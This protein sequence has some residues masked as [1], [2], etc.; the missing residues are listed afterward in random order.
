[1]LSKNEVKYIHSLFRKKN[2][3]E[4]RLFIAEGPKL[5]EELLRTPELITHVYATQQWLDKYASL[6]IPCTEVSEVEL[7]KITS[8]KSANEVLLIAKQ[9]QPSGEPVLK[10]QLTLLLDGIQ[11]PGNMGTIIRI[12]DWFGINQ[13][14]CTDDCVDRYNSKV[15]QSTMGSL[16]RVSCWEM[17]FNEWSIDEDVPVYGAMLKG[18]NIY[19]LAKV[20]EGV[21]V[22]GHESQGIREPLASQVTHAVTIPKIGEAESLNAAVATGIIVGC[23]VCG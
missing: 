17:R 10:N 13:I 2:R 5:A 12:A 8:L 4:E 18:Q 19:Q 16:L 11:D 9:Q 3:D 1:M 14:I 6:Q 22:I 23:M 7:D 15:V 21:I 20:H